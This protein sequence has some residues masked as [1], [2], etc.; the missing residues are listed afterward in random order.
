MKKKSDDLSYESGF[1]NPCLRRSEGYSSQHSVFPS[2]AVRNARR[3]R[4][5]FDD[6]EGVT[7]HV[8]ERK[9]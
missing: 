3:D 2:K 4:L 5:F 6:H 8:K 7:W 9:E 1:C